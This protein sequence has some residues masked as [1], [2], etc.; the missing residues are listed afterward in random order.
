MIQ[1]AVF[2]AFLLYFFRVFNYISIFLPKTD[3]EEPESGTVLS[4][5]RKSFSGWKFP[6]I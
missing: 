5:K 2:H 4:E 1:F 6:K 3:E